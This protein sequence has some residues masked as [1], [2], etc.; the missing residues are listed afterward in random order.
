MKQLIDGIW[1]EPPAARDR[2]VRP[3]SVFR[4]WVTRDGEPGLSG[5]GGFKAD[6][7]RYHL[8]VS[9]ACPWAHRTLIVRALKG[10]SGM[11]GVSAVNALVADD[12][13]TF[14]PGP[15]VIPDT[16]NG[17]RYLRDLYRLADPRCTTRVTVPVLWDKARR[18]I[19]SNESAEILRMFNSAFDGVGA[20]AG[21]YAPA[22]LLEEI[23]ALNARIY[24][25]LNNGVYRAGFAPT[26]AAHAQAVSEVF[27]TLGLL[28]A[29]LADGR[30]YLFG[31]RLTEADIRL[32]PT[33]IRFEPVYAIHFKCNVRRL[34]DYAWLWAYVR[35]IYRLPQVMP[36]VNIEHI[37]QHYYRSHRML[38]PSG[39]V[40]IGPSPGL[41]DAS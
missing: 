25:T 26:Q 9:W 2:F 38:N 37:K 13:W 20:A 30:P 10:L 36:T 14:D 40:P 29:R 23:D 28:E 4:N 15:D 39:L 41:E 19:V 31:E 24:E 21:D 33:L 7:D 8:Y 34:Q 18:T 32:F 17:V 6:P 27:E 5:T 11:I 3:P 35:R 12:G 1:C 16:V 22:E